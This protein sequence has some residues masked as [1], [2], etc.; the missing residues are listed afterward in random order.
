MITQ[1][2]TYNEA[3]EYEAG[4]TTFVGAF[5]TCLFGR[6]HFESRCWKRYKRYINFINLMNNA[7]A[8]TTF[9]K[10][11]DAPNPNYRGMPRKSEKERRGELRISR[12]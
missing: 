11:D 9:H 6:K 12:K 4:R 1:Y 2:I 10:G 8:G 7:Q 5:F 3:L